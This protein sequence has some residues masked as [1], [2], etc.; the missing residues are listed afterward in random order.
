MNF[1]FTT[2]I[3]LTGLV[4]GSLAGS[5]STAPIPI[6]GTSSNDTLLGTSGSDA[7][8]GGAGA[9]FM[10]GYAGD[11]FYTVDNKFDV[12]VEQPDEGCDTI[13][14]NFSYWTNHNNWLHAEF[15]SSPTNVEAVVMGEDDFD[16][17]EVVP[18]TFAHV[19][20]DPL[21]W[22]DLMDHNQFDNSSNFTD[23]CTMASIANTMTMLGQELTEDEALAY[24]LE[25]NHVG[26]RDTGNTPPWE[27]EAALEGLGCVA[28][29]YT[30]VQSKETIAQWLEDGHV[31]ILGV[32]YGILHE[33]HVPRGF[34]DHAITLT[35]VAYDETTGNLLG[36]YYCDSGDEFDHSASIYMPISLFYEAHAQYTNGYNAQMV[37]VDAPLKVQRDSYR[38]LGNPDADQVIIGNHGDNQIITTNGNDYAEGGAGNDDFIDVA[39]GDDVFVPGAGNDQAMWKNGR[40]SLVLSIGGGNDVVSDEDAEEDEL[41]FDSTIDKASIFLTLNNTDLTVHYGSNS[42][43]RIVDYSLAHDFSLRTFDACVLDAA[44]L[45]N[46]VSAMDVYCTAN[47]VDFSNPEAVS[48]DAGLAA[49]MASGWQSDTNALRYR[50]WTAMHRLEHE[51][52]G[53]S[54]AAADDGVANL[55]KYAAGFSPLDSADLFSYSTD[56]ENNRFKMQYQKSK[57]ADAELV[58]EWSGALSNDW[59]TV[60]I[61]TSLLSETPSNELWEA[62]LPA[63]QTG[64]MRLRATLTE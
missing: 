27:V 55:L 48:A 1:H 53:F 7:I 41:V 31:I 6:L 58:A 43:V 34:D 64:F 10:A 2:L 20:G 15:Y 56:S 52:G 11:D 24:M 46:L 17:V 8:D 12:V 30:V 59:S 29:L 38:V 54:E 45:S 39:A 28:T 40:D 32:D 4:T 9:D 5:V 50:V 16:V 14:L 62:S 25:N 18:G 44:G 13:K 63:G 33:E 21:D 23:T 57:R 42:N 36:Y 22:R 51:V 3:L 26:N 35:G 49:L 19:Y 60:G 61:E 47:A 37:L